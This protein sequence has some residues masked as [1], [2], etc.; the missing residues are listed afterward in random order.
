MAHRLR[1]VEMKDVQSSEEVQVAQEALQRA[2]EDLHEAL[3]M[4]DALKALVAK[5]SPPAASEEEG[6]AIVG[7]GRTSRCSSDDVSFVGSEYSD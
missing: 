6:S 7:P 3:A 4:I 2:E 1:L 5:L